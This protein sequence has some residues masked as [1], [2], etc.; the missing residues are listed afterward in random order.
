MLIDP[1]ILL[2]KIRL[3]HYTGTAFRHSAS[4]M[5]QTPEWNTDNINLLADENN[6]VLIEEA[7]SLIFY[8]EVTV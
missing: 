5:F 3:P 4:Q 1:L 8:E 7:D 6:N 2:S